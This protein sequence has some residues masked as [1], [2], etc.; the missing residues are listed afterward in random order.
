VWGCRLK[1]IQALE[2]NAQTLSDVVTALNDEHSA[3][4]R[5][6]AA[7]L[8][9]SGM[10]EAVEP[11]C[12]SLHS[13]SSVVV[14]RTAGDA[15]SDL[16]DTRAIA[17]LGQALGDRSKL[18]R[19]RAAR[20]LDEI[21]DETAVPFLRRAAEQETEFDVRL[22]MLAA[23]DRISGGG[24]AQ[25]PMWMRISGGSPGPQPASAQGTS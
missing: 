20:F 21:G 25:L 14:R 24:E 9:A 7:I 10:P 13:D 2:V 19:W 23:S 4:R 5:W 18:G 6:A 22:E 17:T 11:L 16:G 12:R 8:G 1:A 15:L 3:V